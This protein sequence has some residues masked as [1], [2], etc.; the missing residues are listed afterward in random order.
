MVVVLKRKKKQKQ[1]P[2]KYKI[3]LNRLSLEHA[4]YHSRFKTNPDEVDI[5]NP[6]LK[7]IYI[8]TKKGI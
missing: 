7:L 8:T 4:L 2:K 1:Y 6:V 3:L 5:A